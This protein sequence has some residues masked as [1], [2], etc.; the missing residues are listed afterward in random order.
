MGR[1]TTKTDVLS[2][3]P[4]YVSG[5]LDFP[6]GVSFTTTETLVGLDGTG[7]VNLLSFYNTK[8]NLVSNVFLVNLD[9]DGVRAMSATYTIA[10]SGQLSLIGSFDEGG[11]AP[12][13]EPTP[14]RST[15]R[16]LVKSIGAEQSLSMRYT[17]SY[18]WVV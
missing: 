9:I 15:F 5:P 12:G 8:D 6:A 17:L 7:Y 3:T 11:S 16:F 18:R 13:Y 14:F 2:K 4:V 10:G 1:N